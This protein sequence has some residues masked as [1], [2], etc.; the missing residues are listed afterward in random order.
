MFCRVWASTYLRRGGVGREGDV[1]VRGRGMCNAA[2]AGAPCLA[3]RSCRV[4]SLL[5]DWPGLP[6]K[7]NTAAHGTRDRKSATAAHSCCHILPHCPSKKS[8][9][10][11][12]TCFV[13]TGCT[14]SVRSK[15]VLSGLAAETC[16]DPVL[17]AQL[18]KTCLST[19]DPSPRLSCHQK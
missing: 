4:R 15:P 11:S 16:P 13:R 9:R 10:P 12:A 3:P 7:S 6:C 14:R 1:P 8:I 17:P 19:A 18:R 5:C 2:C